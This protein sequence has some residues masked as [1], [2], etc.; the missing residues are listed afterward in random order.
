METKQTQ[1][2]DVIAINKKATL[3]TIF[4]DIGNLP[5]Q[6]EADVKAQGLETDGPM[7]FVYRGCSGDMESPFDLEITQPV[8]STSAYR[9]NF[10][11][12]TLPPFK[13]VERTYKGNIMEIG[14]KGYE[15][16]ITDLEN[17]GL[18]MTDQAR[19]IYTLYEGPESENNVTELQI[20]V[21]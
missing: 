17:Q 3:K 1:P 6:L 11:T 13:C 8:K 20:G 14:P 9:G 15:P 7:I 18:T 2:I 12:S 5:E 16:F 19:E 4:A 21:K 10:Q